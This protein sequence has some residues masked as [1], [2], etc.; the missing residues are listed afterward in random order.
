MTAPGLTRVRALAGPDVAT[1]LRR[2]I[3]GL[4]VLGIVGTSIELVFLRHWTEAT[5]LIVWPAMLLLAVGVWIVARQ[6]T[7]ARIQWARR[8]AG[9]VLVVAALGV[10]IHVNANLEAA[11]LDADY[12]A[13]WSTL[14]TIQQW[15]LAITGGVGPAPTLAP[16]AL[17]EIAL[18]LLL[19]TF[20]HPESRAD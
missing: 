6:P 13:T 9:V 1:T 18:A 10:L 15:W 2:G 12:E 4:A 17:A 8:L 11:P 19:A 16:G 14:P 20:A 5:Q 7:R 3:L